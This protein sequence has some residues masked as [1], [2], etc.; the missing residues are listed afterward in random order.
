[1]KYAKGFPIIVIIVLINIVLT[2]FLEITIRRPIIYYEYIFLPILLIVVNKNIYRTIILI[3]LIL[4]DIVYNLSHL[5]FFDIFNYIGKIPYLYIAKFNLSFWILILLGLCLLFWLCKFLIKIFDLKL[6]TLQDEKLKIN[7]VLSVSFF[8][9]VYII[10]SLN[11]TSLIGEKD[12]GKHI[13]NITTENKK[14][15]NVG[16]SLIK[17]LYNDYKLFQLGKKELYEIAD[18]KNINSDSS[19]SYKYFYN[20][21]GNK[22]VVIVLESWGLLLNNELLKDQIAPF[23]KIDSSKY[24]ITF[25]KS[26]FNGATLQAESRELLNKVGEAYFSVINHNKCDIK[27]LIKKKA[28]QDYTT[29]AVQPFDGTYSVGAKF[30]KL[31]GFE[32]FRDYK[33]FHDTLGLKTIFNNQYQSVL[34]EEVFAYIFENLK[35]SKKNFTYCLTINT[36]LPFFLTKE[37]KDDTNFINFREIYK[38]KFPNEEMLGMYYRMNQELK[39]IANLISMSDVDKVLIIGDHAPPYIFK[40]ERNFFAPYYVPSILIEKKN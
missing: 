5:Y 2:G 8:I 21:D 20:S 24:K 28:A 33:F 32:I 12:K 23:Y 4:L 29:M 39:S 7:I 19:F 9:M 25:K 11:G 3:G 36:H 17:E 10:D 31:I 34:D 15:Y 27:N 37:Q 6:K 30:K 22:E 40:N 1:M 16:K 14:E 13:I 35:K 18:F 26:Y 38:N